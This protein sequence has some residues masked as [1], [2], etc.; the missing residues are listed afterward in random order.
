MVEKLHPA[1]KAIREAPKIVDAF[2]LL[3]DVPD[4][5]VFVKGGKRLFGDGQ[6]DYIDKDRLAE[7]LAGAK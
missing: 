7:I 6:R 3:V 1:I 5:L 4:N 2:S